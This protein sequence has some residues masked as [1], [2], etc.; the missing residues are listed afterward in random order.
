LQLGVRRQATLLPGNH[1]LT[2]EEVPEI[3]VQ[4]P[5]AFLYEP[6]GAVIRAHLVEQLAVQL[7]AAK[8]SEDIAYLTADSHQ[9]TPF[10]RTFAIEDS[11]PFQLK[12]LRH[13]LRERKIGRVTIKKRGSPLDPDSLQKQLRLKGDEHRIIFLTQVQREPVVLIGSAL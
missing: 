9:F 1:V 13:Y 2:S 3:P 5:G 12:R 7:N 4:Q 10:A 11:F 8:I 6:D